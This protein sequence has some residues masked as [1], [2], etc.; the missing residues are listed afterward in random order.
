MP[1]SQRRAAQSRLGRACTECRQVKLR[2]DSTVKFPAP[3]SRCQATG[4]ACTFDPSFK[5]TP[6]RGK[7]ERITKELDELQRVLKKSSQ[8]QSIAAPSTTDSD[9]NQ[10]ASART[11]GEH[12]LLEH[13]SHQ[14]SSVD[15][16]AVAEH[17]F[18]LQDPTVLSSCPS[19]QL[20]PV[21]V[22][23][24]SVQRLFT[25][26]SRHHY[27]HLP[28]LD[29]R[30]TYVELYSRIPFL[31]WTIIV[32][33]CRYHPI[34]AHLHDS[35]V[36]PYH[37]FL[38]KVL[39]KAPLS[40]HAIQALLL[41]CLW[42]FPVMTQLYDPSLGYSAMAVSAAKDL[43]LYKSSLSP[44]SNAASEEEQIRMKTW[45]A[46]FQ[47]NTSLST[48]RGISSLLHSP[49][50]LADIGRALA[51]GS[52]PTEFAAQV[53]IQRQISSHINILPIDQ[54]VSANLSAVQTFEEDLGSLERQFHPLNNPEINFMVLRAKLNLYTQTLVSL[55]RRRREEASSRATTGSTF[56]QNQYYPAEILQVKIFETA[57]RMIALF[58][59]ILDK[60]PPLTNVQ[61]TTRPRSCYPKYYLHGLIF[62]SF[63]LVRL[64]AFGT[65]ELHHLFEHTL[66][67]AYEAFMRDSRHPLDEPARA[68]QLVEV[69]SRMT[70]DVEMTVEDRAG[71]SVVYDAIRRAGE[72]R[73]RRSL[74][75]EPIPEVHFDSQDGPTQ[76]PDSPNPPL[77]TPN[78]Q[79]PLDQADSQYYWMTAGLDPSSNIWGFGE[80]EDFDALMP[81]SP[82][83]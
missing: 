61:A 45:L 44:H 9:G 33:T 51:T 29:T 26:F 47:V 75:E 16:D 31:F 57:G 67:R 49:S 6:T 17:F 25:L 34:D 46:C 80:I 10:A 54:S 23:A 59:D 48:F 39:C 3:C 13:D 63:T 5:R 42:P 27:R 15:D 66:K 28:I 52:L 41:L 58:H 62:A 64:F 55:H 53:E 38:G 65:H 79:V 71:A 83:G 1:S 72:L 76:R 32:V 14:A 20:G 70:T 82:Q 81:F 56:N 73:A 8:S 74:V 12:A 60:T 7:L 35:L 36:Q 18:G 11:G 24:A 21:Q 19:F 4:R 30:K 50:E 78:A 77:S 43:R 2:C 68:A 69:V 37:Q 22:S 40:L